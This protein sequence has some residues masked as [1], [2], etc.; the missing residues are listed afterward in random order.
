MD[1]G[2]FFGWF[3]TRSMFDFSVAPQLH[4]VVVFMQLKVNTH[5]GTILSWD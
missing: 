4:D 5:S 3:N 2:L 1:G